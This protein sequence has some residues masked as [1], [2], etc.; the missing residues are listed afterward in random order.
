[1]ADRLLASSLGRICRVLGHGD[2]YRW[3]EA[4]GRSPSAPGASSR[5]RADVKGA[6]ERRCDPLQ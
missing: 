6:E 2:Q 4:A 5:E 3:R 1:V